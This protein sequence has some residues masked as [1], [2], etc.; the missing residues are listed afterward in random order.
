MKKNILLLVVFLSATILRSNNN[1]SI[2]LRIHKFEVELKSNEKCLK[3]FQ[4]QNDSLKAE[5]HR[6][7]SNDYKSFEVITAVN[8]YYDNAWGKLIYLISALAGIIVFVIPIA[9]NKLQRRELR[10][11]KE[12]FQE[13][14]DKKIVEFEKE[15][16]AHNDA[17]IKE[18]SSQIEQNQRVE[19]D[20]LWSMTY[21]MQGVNFINAK[22]YP[23]ALK[24][25]IWSIEKQVAS[26]FSKNIDNTF[27]RI[28]VALTE[29][30]SK[31]E[32]I[33]E[34]L[35]KELAEAIEKVL[36]EYQG[37]YDEIIEKVKELNKINKSVL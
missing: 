6:V 5:L 22:N 12:D 31:K 27:S 16:K 1:D 32:K 26:K 19:I 10:L 7:L 18:F 35:D 25:L 4:M 13:Y 24:S 8:D 28:N 15:I 21:F 29:L 11:N 3:L 17:R 14:V 20:K 9:L 30:N 36:N 2:G 23:V 34:S 37:E 33:T